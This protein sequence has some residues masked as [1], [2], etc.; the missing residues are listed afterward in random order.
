MYTLT[1]TFFRDVD[2]TGRI[3]CTV[4][5]GTADVDGTGLEVV[6]AVME[7]FLRDVVASVTEETIRDVDGTG[8]EFDKGRGC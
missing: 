5:A 8:L 3:S 2:A 4:V 7:E 6:A 1:I